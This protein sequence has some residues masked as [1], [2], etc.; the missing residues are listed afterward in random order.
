MSDVPTFGYYAGGEW[1]G[2]S[3][4]AIFEVVEPYSRKL[5]SRVAACGAR[6]HAMQS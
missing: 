1:K 4:N 5:M 6:R 3:G 2:A